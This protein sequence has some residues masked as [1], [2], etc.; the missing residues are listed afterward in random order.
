MENNVTLAEKDINELEQKIIKKMGDGGNESQSIVP[1]LDEESRNA[2]IWDIGMIW[3]GAQLIVGT[4]AVGALAVAVFGLDLIGAVT[5]IIFGNIIG[6]IMVGATSLMGRHGAPQMIMTR[7]GLGVKG[8]SIT[9]FFNFISTVGWFSANTVLTALACFQVFDII[10]I[11]ATVLLKS[12]LLLIIVGL[13]LIF[14]LTNFKM[15]KKIEAFLV[16]PM[17]ILILVMTFIAMKDVN[18]VTKASGAAKGSSF[19]YWSMWISAAGAVGISYLGSWSPYAS[20][21]SRYFKFKNKKAVKQIFWVPLLV[22]SIIGIWLEV[23][24]AT[25]ATKFAGADPALHI[26]KAIPSFA[27]PALIVI[28]AGLFSTNVL[29]LVAGGLSAK[30]I[31]KKGTRTQWT[32]IIAVLGSIMAAYSVFVS[33][34]A[35]VYH[36]FLIALLIWQAPWFAITIVDYF[37]VRKGDYR[38]E[39]LYRLNNLIPD[40]N[41]KGMTAYWIGFIAACLTS[42]TGKNAIFGIPLYSPI[43]LKYFNGMDISF[44]VGFAVA[45]AAYYALSKAPAAQEESEMA[46]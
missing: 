22:G 29:N 21:F 23:I 12:L 13:Q 11:K 24:G 17:A 43:M 27:L 37:I 44:F 3:A 41:K 9:S 10:G 39:D 40:Y 8:A 38:I 42:F 1:V 45:A 15:M 33:D 46:A 16:I 19:N 32:T 5:S 4:W 30:V 34:I 31:W 2:S 14:S 35:T 6:G 28:L 36:T 7:Y 18:W 26:A 20:D 25:F